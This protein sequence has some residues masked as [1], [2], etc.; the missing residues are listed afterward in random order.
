MFIYEGIS[1]SVAATG[2]T[3]W[4]LNL[5][6]GSLNF[7]QKKDFVFDKGKVDETC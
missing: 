1:V 3:F 7:S 4:L 6:T 5:T 2:E